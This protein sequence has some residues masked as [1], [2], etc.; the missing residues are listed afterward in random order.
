[1]LMLAGMLLSVGC[2][3]ERCGILPDSPFSAKTVAETDDR[4]GEAVDEAALDPVDEPEPVAG[5]VLEPVDLLAD[6]QA[7]QGSAGPGADRLAQPVVEPVAEP[8]ASRSAVRLSS[9]GSSGVGGLF[10]LLPLGPGLDTFTTDC[11]LSED[12]YATC[13]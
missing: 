1:M 13:L 3:G 8:V 7:P 10:P 12:P 6:E 5:S 4:Y 9:G 11:D 2:Y